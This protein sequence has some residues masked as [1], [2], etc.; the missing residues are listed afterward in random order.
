MYAEL[1]DA[2]IENLTVFLF[3]PRAT[4]FGQ[5]LHLA[6]WFIAICLILTSVFKGIFETTHRNV[7]PGATLTGAA[8]VAV[9]FVFHSYLF[10]ASLFFGNAGAMVVFILW[11]TCVLSTS[12]GGFCLTYMRLERRGI[13]TTVRDFVVRLKSPAPPN[14]AAG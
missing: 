13:H 14:R 8:V 11:A 1:G 12:G 2:L 3:A 10:P 6:G 7:L 5:V 4:L 9:S